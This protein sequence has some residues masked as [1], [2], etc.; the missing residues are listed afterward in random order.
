MVDQPADVKVAIESSYAVSSDVEYVNR[1]EKDV[2]LLFFRQTHI[3]LYLIRV[4][5]NSND[6]YC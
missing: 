2:A 5:V 6:I 4:V 3:R 1:R